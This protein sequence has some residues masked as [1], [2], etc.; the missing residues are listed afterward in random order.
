[1]GRDFPATVPDLVEARLPGGADRPAL[2]EKDRTVTYGELS[3]R[4]DL[5]AS[6]LASLGILRG[7]RVAIDLSNSIEA[8]V[9]TLAVTRRG[10]VFV[11][12]PSQW[13]TGQIRQALDDCGAALLFTDARRME[14]LTSGRG[15][16]GLPPAIVHGEGKGFPGFQPPGGCARTPRPVPCPV[17]PDDLAAL[18]YTSGSSGRPKGVMVSHRNLVDGARIVSGYLDHSPEDRVLGL[19][20]FSFDYGLNQLTSMLYSGGA[21]VLQQVALPS[22]IVRA[23]G[24]HRVTGIAF[25]PSLW[26]RFVKYLRES[27]AVIPSLRYLTNSGGAIPLDLL[28]TTPA[29]LPG[30]SLYLMYGLTEAFRSTFLPPEMYERKMGSIG[31]PIPEVDVYVVNS[32]TGICKAGETGELIHGGKL[33]CQGYWKDPAGTAEML[34]ENPHLHPVTGAR[35]VLHSGDLVRCDDEGYLWFVGR[36]DDLIKCSGFRISPGEVEEILCRSGLVD[37]AVALG[38]DDE[39]YG[40]VVH[41]VLP[42]EEGASV[43]SR[44]IERHCRQKMPSY[45]IP[46]RIHFWGEDFPRTAHG[47]IDRKIVVETLKGSM[48]Y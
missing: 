21:V 30:V 10:G 16:E 29:L 24:K 42:G 37:E 35:K 11:N 41:V 2:F 3:Q 36:S 43:D 31:K 20:P 44:T 5:A 19:L 7:D 26:I 17:S 18:F 15:A 40:Q 46:R 25:I 8:V 12:I 9:A 34:R 1:M 32:E 38:K 4:V 48:G 14:K 13:K 45:M 39:A 6:R 47:K 33:V 23:A 28:E 22:E 27:G